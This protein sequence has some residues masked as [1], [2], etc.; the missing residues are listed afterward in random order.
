[1]RD[2]KITVTIGIPAYNEDIN[3]GFLIKD[4]LGQNRES[5]VLGKIV[6][7]SDGST[8]K[9]VEIAKGFKNKK[10]LILDNKERKGIAERENQII[11][12]TQSDVLVLLNADTRIIQK[13]FLKDLVMPITSEEIDLT[14]SHLR[15][16]EPQGFFEKVLL[17]SMRIKDYAYGEFKGGNNVY[18]CCG[19]ARAFSKRLY[20]SLHFPVSL[21]EDAY[22]YFYC[23]S[24]GFRYKSTREIDILYKL[25]TSFADHQKQSIR[26]FQSQKSLEREFDKK[27]IKSEYMIPKSLLIKS[28]LRMFL[29]FP[30]HTIFY[31]G[32]VFYLKLKSP[33]VDKIGD[34]WAISKSSKELTS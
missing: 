33:L 16:I 26:F 20:K 28:V 9:T 14:S 34:T 7:A 17:I 8:D 19:C 27:F 13:N 12:C 18:T 15:E 24:N 10:I 21:G 2:K 11:S 25:P 6:I 30:I 31:L 22:S 32:L 4:I 23:I 3:I 29:K 1:M 5:F